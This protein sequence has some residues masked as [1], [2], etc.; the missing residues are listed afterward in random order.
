M[1]D[2]LFLDFNMLILKVGI[3]YLSRFKFGSKK[4]F[5]SLDLKVGQD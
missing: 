5:K 4:R 2:G 3:K 1:F